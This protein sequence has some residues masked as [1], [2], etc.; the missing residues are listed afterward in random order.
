VKNPIK[1]GKKSSKFR[2]KSLRTF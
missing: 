1:S 2:T